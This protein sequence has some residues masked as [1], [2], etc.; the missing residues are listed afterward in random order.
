MKRLALAAV[1]AFSM[2]GEA[3]AFD[4]KGN[5]THLGRPE[6]GEYLDAYSRSTLE[7][8]GNYTGTHSFYKA[9]GFINGF[10]TAY[11]RY[12]P[13]DKSHSL[14]GMT[15][16]DARRWLA[17]WCRDNGSRDLEYALEALIESRE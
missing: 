12:I 11:N 2:S 6:C 8:E 15:I 7:G 14:S 16:N 13:N 1:L 3:W 9:A 4:A 17:S 5:Y 10:I